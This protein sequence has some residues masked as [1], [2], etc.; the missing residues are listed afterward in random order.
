MSLTKIK[1]SELEKLLEDEE[2]N[3]VEASIATWPYWKKIPDKLFNLLNLKKL[4]FC[5]MHIEIPDYIDIL[6]NL[7]SLGLCHNSIKH[8]NPAIYNLKNLRELDLEKNCIEVL[9]D[10]ISKLK[11]LEILNLCGNNLKVLQTEIYELEN[12][13]QLSLSKNNLKNLPIGIFKLKNLKRLNLQENYLEKLPD[14]ICDVL[15]LEHLCIRK[16]SIFV[17]PEYIFIKLINLKDVDLSLNPIIK[18]PNGISTLEKLF[19][20]NF[21]GLN[22]DAYPDDFID[23]NF[24]TICF[25]SSIPKIR[26]EELFVITNNDHNVVLNLP[27]TLKNMIV[28]KVTDFILTNLP[29]TLSK[30]VLMDTKKEQL[31]KIPFG[32]S[33]VIHNRKS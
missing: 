3:I 14:D 12:L 8:L 28:I 7:E 15:S 26:N 25:F 13:Q 10:G 23:F 2:L 24:T 6:M 9:S 19:Q 31:D 27:V 29:V 11:N 1:A 22:P 18:I 4:I 33:V 5:N 30:I 20:Y 16:N 17:L 32:C 21:Y